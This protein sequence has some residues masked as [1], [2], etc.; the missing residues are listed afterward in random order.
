MKR[1]S[2]LSYGRRKSKRYRQ[3]DDE[4]DAMDET[5]QGGDSKEQMEKEQSEVEK[6]MEE[7]DIEPGGLK[8][9][10]EE[11]LLVE[12]SESEPE[13]DSD[14]ELNSDQGQSEEEEE[15]VEM[16]QTK[17]MIVAKDI[18]MISVTVRRSAI[19]HCYAQLGYPDDWEWHG[20]DGTISQV[21]AKLDLPLGSRNTVRR[22]FQQVVQ[23]AKEG[24]AYDPE[25][26]GG[27]G[28]RR[29][30]DAS[31]VDMRI[32]A[33]MME[34]GF[35]LRSTAEFVN[36]Y[37]VE[38]GLVPVGVSS[39]YG[40][41]LRMEPVVT[42]ILKSKQGSADAESQWAKGRYGWVTQLAVMFG[43]IPSQPDVPMFDRAVVGTL[44]PAQIG[45]W[46]ETHKQVEVG[47]RRRQVRFRRNAN[48]DYDR[49]LRK[50]AV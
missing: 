36:K 1:K 5:Q 37:R 49:L 33:D 10:L 2:D 27:G 40:A 4:K 13:L 16:S 17:A 24:V 43:W 30:I 12:E 46:D 45:W 47:A 21:I 26:R 14:G 11:E 48:G 39:V 25:V 8:A 34:Q 41:Y 35:S 9:T 7:M 32:I 20:R 22:V 29:L 3:K 31:S 44:D 19:A 15:E 28:R 50:R 38:Q 6:P 18:V 42:P 23:C